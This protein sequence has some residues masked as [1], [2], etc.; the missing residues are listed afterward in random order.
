MPVK[1]K[2]FSPSFDAQWHLFCSQISKSVRLGTEASLY[3]TQPQWVQHEGG[4]WNHLQAHPLPPPAGDI[5]GWSGP[6]LGLELEHQHVVYPWG[7]LAFLMPWWP[8][9]PVLGKGRDNQAEAVLSFMTS[10]RPSCSNP[11]ST[12]GVEATH[13]G[14]TT[15]QENRN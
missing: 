12:D 13:K 11:P 5:G 15:Y 4:V 7:C 10:P 2:W 14:Q 3:S 9:H 8:P 1:R 6:R